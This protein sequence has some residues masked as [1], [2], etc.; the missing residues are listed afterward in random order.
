MADRED[1]ALL[2]QLAQWGT[3][4]NIEES[5]QTI[6]AD[7]FDPQ[8]AS[9]KDPVVARVL[10]FGETVGT[11]TKNG[12][13]DTALALDWLWVS[14]IW[15]RVGPAAQRARDEA[16]VQELYENFEALASQQE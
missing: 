11:L 13:F 2:V 5:V 8:T 7:D 3:A 14:G 9:W 16:G 10:Q 15:Q 1:A 6:F 4:L 12:L